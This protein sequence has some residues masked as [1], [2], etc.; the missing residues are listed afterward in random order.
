ADLTV[1]DVCEIRAW[2]EWRA[3]DNSFRG[4]IDS[5]TPIQFFQQVSDLNA[6]LEIFHGRLSREI[7]SESS[8]LRHL[9]L[10][11]KAFLTVLHPVLVWAGTL[12]T[13]PGA[14]EIVASAVHGAVEIG[15]DISLG[16]L[17]ERH[18]NAHNAE[19]EGF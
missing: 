17:E 8:S 16:F 4:V 3:F 14:A 13:G 11:S 12:V 18:R 19:I 7:V 9:R 2:P 15:I 1:R 10:G 5:T 6:T